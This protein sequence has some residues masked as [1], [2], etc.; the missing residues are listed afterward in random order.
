MRCGHVSKSHAREHH[1]WWYYGQEQA[2]KLWEQQM[3]EGGD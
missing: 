2:I 1:A 3:A